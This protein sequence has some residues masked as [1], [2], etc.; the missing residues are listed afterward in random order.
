MNSL[1]QNFPS[2]YNALNY[3][4]LNLPLLKEYTYRNFTC[5]N[6]FTILPNKKRLWEKW[7]VN[8]ST[9][10]TTRHIISYNKKFKKVI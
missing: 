1:D 9:Y 10:E 6:T 8:N 7:L 2:I 5:F 4:Q 3:K